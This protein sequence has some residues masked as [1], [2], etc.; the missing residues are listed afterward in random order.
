MQ[1]LRKVWILSLT[2]TPFAV[3]A[4]ASDQ[5]VN[6]HVAKTT[7]EEP[8]SATEP[9]M[10]VPHTTDRVRLELSKELVRMLLHGSLRKGPG[11]SLIFQNGE[12][13]TKINPKF[14]SCALLLNHLNVREEDF[15]LKVGAINTDPVGA[16]HSRVSFSHLDPATI[17]SLICYDP[18]S[19]STRPLTPPT[20]ERIRSVIGEKQLTIVKDLQRRGDPL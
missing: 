20:Y 18:Q 8:A 13:V 17:N 16:P 3:G 19:D 12:L 14:A 1:I 9:A 15:S 10:G 4:Q 5:A 2:G 7:S 11:E 6:Q